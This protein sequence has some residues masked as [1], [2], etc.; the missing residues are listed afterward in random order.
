MKT[1]AYSGRRWLGSGRRPCEPRQQ[2]FPVGKVDVVV[3][4]YQRDEETLAFGGAAAGL[5]P[6][7]AHPIADRVE[8][9]RDEVHGQQRVGQS[10]VAVPEVVFQVIMPISA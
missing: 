10:L 5:F 1:A 7:R 3:E 2:L 4:H 9:A 6:Q 8:R